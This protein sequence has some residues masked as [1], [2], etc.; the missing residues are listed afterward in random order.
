MCGVVAGLPRL[1]PRA[2]GEVDEKI[3]RMLSVGMCCFRIGV[4]LDRDTDMRR[5]AGST[6]GSDRADDEGAGRGGGAPCVDG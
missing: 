6:G 4:S 3:H 1:A 2:W 5:A